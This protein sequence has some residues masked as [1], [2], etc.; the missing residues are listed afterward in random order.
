MPNS[1]FSQLPKFA[2]LIEHYKV[3][4][5]EAAAI[6]ETIS[7]S[8]YLC[9]HFIHMQDHDDDHEGDHEQ[10][11]LHNVSGS[12][13]Y[14]AQVDEVVAS[15]L[16]IVILPRIPF[17]ASSIPDGIVSDFFHPPTSA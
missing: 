9:I 8:E 17:I 7:F 6:G 4:K 11:P 3:H 12:S 13:F 1:D 5:A 2:D 10:L 14:Y 15:T 16:S